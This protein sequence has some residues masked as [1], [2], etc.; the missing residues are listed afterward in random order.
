[1]RVVRRESTLLFAVVAIAFFG[2]LAG[3]A[4]AQQ[5][6]SVLGIPCTTQADG[7]QACIGDTAHRVKSWDGVPLDVNIYLPPASEH[8]PFPL[9]AYHH[10]YGGNKNG[11][12]ADPALALSGYA[13]MSYSARGFGESCGSAASRAADPSGCAKGWIHLD[14]ARFEARD[15]Q[16]LAGRLAD[17]KLVKPRRIGVTGISYGAG[18]SFILAALRNRIELP[19]GTFKRWRSPHGKRMRIA[20]AAPQWGWSDLAA[21]LMPNG[22]SL[23]YLVDNPYGSRIGVAKQ[24]QGLLYAV[25][26]GSGYYAP[27]GVDPDADITGW[28]GRIQ[29]V[30]P[31]TTRSRSTSSPRSS[32]ITLSITCSAACA[33]AARSARRRSSPTT[34]GSTTSSTATSRCATATRS[35]ISSRTRSSRSC[36]R[37]RQGIRAPA[38]PPRPSS[39]A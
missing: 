19:D 22:N 8:G 25:G 34:P 7:V 1:M 29:A 20:A 32:S 10:G 16:T 2:L 12:G 14:D 3:R 24:Y 39:A 31:T 30:S 13:V 33:A 18:V 38:G 4:G 28:F 26:A 9:V 5:V 6:S 15:T 36:S 17:L 21:S 35:S 23:D 27:V 11:A 37:R